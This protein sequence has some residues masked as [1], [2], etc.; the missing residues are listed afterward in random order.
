M[1]WI[2]Y[3]ALMFFASVALYLC[4]RK[5]S[6]EK[7]PRYLT[8]LAMFAVPLLVY[9]AMSLPQPVDFSLTILQWTLLIVTA[10][11]FAYGGNVASLK[12][13]DIAPNAG[14][15]L[16]LSKS[17]VVFTTIVAVLLFSAASLSSERTRLVDPQCETAA[18]IRWSYAAVQ[19]AIL[20]P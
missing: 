2:A 7:V 14:Y 16:V 17:Y 19:N 12:A 9:A 6:L 4:V 10:I 1:S 15:S 5:S 11:V 18:L 20:P 8:N 3:S 13:I